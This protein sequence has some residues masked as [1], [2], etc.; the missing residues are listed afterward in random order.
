MEIE[1]HAEGSPCSLLRNLNTL[2]IPVDIYQTCPPGLNISESKNSCV[3]EP[4]LAQYTNNCTITNGVGN[5]TRD[6]GEQFWVGYDDQSHDLILHPHS[7]YDNTASIMK[8]AFLLMSD[9]QCAY[10]RSS[11]LCGACKGY[12]LV[13]GTSQCKQ[14]TNSHLV[15]LIP[16]A[17]M[18]VAFVFSLSAN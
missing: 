3:C 7:P 13:L 15:L 14:S 12:S 1:L 10:N 5:I 16:F 9:K 2:E 8:L 11:L 17:V 4:R 6:S 18:V